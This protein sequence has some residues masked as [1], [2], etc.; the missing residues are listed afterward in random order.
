MEAQATT[1]IDQLLQQARTIAI[2]GLSNKPERDSYKVAMYLMEHGYQVLGVN[3]LLA[4]TE[5]LGQTCYASLQEAV[6]TTGLKIDIVDCFRKAED[7]PAI[8]EAAIAVGAGAIWM[9]L[10][11]VNEQAADMAKAAHMKVVMDRCTK[12]EHKRLHG[13]S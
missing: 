2:V 5:I 7:I 9:Q 11:I 10:E 8:V 3:P 6:D 13:I 12:I 1:E 4:G